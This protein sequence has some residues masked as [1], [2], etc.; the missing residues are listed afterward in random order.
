VFV[1][2]QLAEKK[3]RTPGNAMGI[4]ESHFPLS[5]AARGRQLA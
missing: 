5:W 2:A 3:R 4:A 1:L